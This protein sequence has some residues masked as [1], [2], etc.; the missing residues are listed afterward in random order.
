METIAGC[1]AVCEDESSVR[2]AGDG[3]DGVE[4]FVEQ[5]DELDGVARRACAVVHLRHVG[6]VAIV[7]FVE[8]DSVP[9]GL[10]M[11]LSSESVITVRAEHVWLFCDGSGGVE[12]IEGDSIGDRAAVEVC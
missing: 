10:K 7:R 2:V 6:H 8:V 4:D 9:A 12:T 1:V 3:V 11:D 5:V